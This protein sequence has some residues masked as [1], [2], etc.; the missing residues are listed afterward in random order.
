MATTF[1]TYQGSLTEYHGM[2]V[3]ANLPDPS[4]PGLRSLVLQDEEGVYVE[5]RGV[6]PESIQSQT[7]ES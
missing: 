7:K 2:K 4:N 5:L 6:K 1:Q 3:V